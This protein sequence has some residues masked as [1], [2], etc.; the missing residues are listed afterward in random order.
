MSFKKW[1]EDRRERRRRKDAERL[2]QIDPEERAA[3]ARPDFAGEGEVGLLPQM[4][5]PSSRRLSTRRARPAAARSSSAIVALARGRGSPASS[6]DGSSA[7]ARF[8]RLGLRLAGD[9]V[10]HHPRGGEHR[11]G[12]RHAR[13][14][15]LH[16]GLGRDGA[17]LGLVQRRRVR[18]E[19][20]RVAVGP[21]AHHG[22][23]EGRRPASAASY[24]SAASSGVELALDAV[25]LPAAGRARRA[26]TRGRRGSSSGRRR[27]GRSARRSTR[28]R[29]RSSRA[30]GRRRARR[31]G[32]GP[33][34]RR[35][36]CGRRRRQPRRSAALPPRRSSAVV[37]DAEVDALNCRLGQLPRALHRRLDRVQERRADAGAPRARGSRGSSSRPAR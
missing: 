16:P 33:S 35:G 19:R 32:A 28:A 6:G 10:E 20:R 2:G 24:S 34:R 11:P 21:D 3:A 29:P 25:D 9:E 7:N 26:A 31:P 8:D 22:E 13:D 27:A 12:H 18:E 23:V 30:A 1:R 5:R 4:R 17:P 37:D 36:R 14:E 15:R